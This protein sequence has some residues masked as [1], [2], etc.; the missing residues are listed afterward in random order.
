MTQEIADRLLALAREA[1][2]EQRKLQGMPRLGP[3]ALLEKRP[4]MV[5]GFGLGALPSAHH[6]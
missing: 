1:E 3:W 2:Y 5:R 6:S 4:G